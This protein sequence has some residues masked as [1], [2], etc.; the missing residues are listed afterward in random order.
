MSLIVYSEPESSSVD[1]EPE[2][3]PPLPLRVLKSDW[4]PHATQK[5]EEI[6]ALSHLVLL[7]VDS[8]ASNR[9]VASDT[10]VD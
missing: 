7:L 1:I 4:V 5:L 3:E 10:H 6:G 8:D 2:F 9:R